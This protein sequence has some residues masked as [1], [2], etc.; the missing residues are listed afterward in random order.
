MGKS[1]GWGSRTGAEGS[2]GEESQGGRVGPDLGMGV[3]QESPGVLA[4]MA[5]GESLSQGQ[6][7]RRGPMARG[8]QPRVQESLGIWG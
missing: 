2:R 5:W 7:P 4:R 1:Q 8:W 6:N 3:S